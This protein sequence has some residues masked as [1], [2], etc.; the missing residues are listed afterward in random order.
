ML[1]AAKR[2][3]FSTACIE[4]T[5][6]FSGGGLFVVMAALAGPVPA[7]MYK[8][9]DQQGH[10]QYSDTPV[11]G[12]DVM[13]GA[14]VQ[15]YSA[16]RL[17]VHL[18]PRKKSTKPEFA[19]YKQIAV[20]SPTQDATLWDHDG[21]VTVSAVIDPPLQVALGHKLEFAL[22]GRS[23]TPP[24]QASSAALRNIDRGTHAL[25][26]LVVDEQGGQIAASPPV[27][28]HFKKVSVLNPPA[29]ARRR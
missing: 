14:P 5:K 24:G 4:M 22:D 25:T 10:V 19:G 12:A 8:W 1:F 13:H 26:A 16:P 29:N 20:V 2:L 23:V 17:P 6:I 15:Y 9:V 11:K 27:T 28:F 21:P 7:E 18:K 3:P